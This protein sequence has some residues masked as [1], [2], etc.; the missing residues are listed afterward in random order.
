MS[1]SAENLSG[2]QANILEAKVCGR[3]YYPTSVIDV[4][5]TCNSSELWR[6][7]I[8]GRNGPHDLTPGAFTLTAVPGVLIYSFRSIQN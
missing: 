7:V 3:F 1:L 4:I 2:L 6:I 5:L 8:R